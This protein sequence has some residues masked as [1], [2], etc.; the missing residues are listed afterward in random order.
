MRLL[1]RDNPGGWTG[2]AWLVYLASVPVYPIL[3]GATT[4]EWA[5][6]IASI[7]TFLVL[8]FRGFWVDDRGL[9]WCVA[10][11]AAIGAGLAPI[12]PAAAAY[13]IFASAFLARLKNVKLAVRCIGILMAIVIAESLV[14]SLDPQFWIVALVFVAMIGGV[15]IHYAQVGRAN[16][17]L[18][19]AEDEIVHLA[20]SNE[21]ER[22]ARDLHDVLGHTLSLIILKSELASRLA[23]RDT[24]RAVRE[25]REVEA[26]SREA[27]RE[28]R[29]AITGYR[30]GSL[31]SEISRMGN[32]LETAGVDVETSV[33]PVRLAPAQEGVLALAIREATTNIIRHADARRCSIRLD[34]DHGRCR[35]EV[36]D[37]GRGGSAGEGAGLTG[38]RERIEALG[39]TLE[40]EGHKGTRLMIHLPV[41]D[42][43]IPTG[44][45][46][47]LPA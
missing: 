32:A 19:L 11:I 25:I 14:L 18:K 30:A 41:T 33:E 17:R 44:L 29:A 20:E 42:S 15:N 35:L 22:I 47:G 38:M 1:P 9:L 39:G 23:D 5:W 28:V 46:E 21:R 6:S 43:A 34:L 3:S 12:N 40:R 2:Y 16:A 8:Y 10:G 45:A 24:A 13:F 4:A 31:A 26:I 36:R 37:D 27:L 7:I